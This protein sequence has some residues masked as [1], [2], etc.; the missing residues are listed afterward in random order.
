MSSDLQRKACT[1]F[2]KGHLPN[3]HFN[4]SYLQDIEMGGSV[5]APFENVNFL[6]FCFWKRHAN[7]VLVLVY[8]ISKEEIMMPM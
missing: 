4:L 6:P 3:F 2:W 1:G 7:L 8:Y 5:H